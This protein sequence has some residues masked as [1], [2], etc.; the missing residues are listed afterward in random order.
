MNP[1]TFD[2]IQELFYR[3]QVSCLADLPLLDEDEREECDAWKVTE[4]MEAVD[5]TP[6][7]E[8]DDGALPSPESLQIT[9]DA[10]APAGASTCVANRAVPSGTGVQCARLDVAGARSTS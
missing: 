3:L 2:L 4:D 1:G 6:P 10:A 5:L 7:P 8:D 9:P